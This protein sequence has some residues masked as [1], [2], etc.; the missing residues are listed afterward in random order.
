MKK[1]VAGVMTAAL[2]SGMLLAS[3]ATPN[4]VSNGDFENGMTG[5]IPKHIG[6]ATPENQLGTAG[7]KAEIVSGGHSGKCLKITQGNLVEGGS[8]S[9]FGRVEQNLISKEV[10]KEGSAYMFSA[11]VKAES[12][13]SNVSNPKVQLILDIAADQGDKDKNGNPVYHHQGEVV[14]SEEV[15]TSWKKIT[16]VTRMFTFEQQD[17]PN[18]QYKNTIGFHSSP[19]Y[20]GANPGFDQGL[21]MDTPIK[22]FTPYVILSGGPE[23]AVPLLIDDMELKKPIYNFIFNKANADSKVL[24]KESGTETY[25]HEGTDVAV[26]REAKEDAYFIYKFDF[27]K[28]TKDA[29]ISMNVGDDFKIDVATDP[30]GP[31]TNVANGKAL[32]M[33]NAYKA[34][35]IIDVTGYLNKNSENAVYMKFSDRTKGTTGTKKNGVTIRAL[36]VYS[37]TGALEFKSTP[38]NNTSTTASKN[39]AGQTSSAAGTVSNGKTP[40][41]N[42]VNTET[43]VITSG[44]D[45]V[46]ESGIVAESGEDVVSEEQQDSSAVMADSENEGGSLLWLWITLAVVVVLGGGGAALYFLVIKKKLQK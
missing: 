45:I 38:T 10:P 11:W 46:T 32:L 19:K 29:I 30:N 8:L 22:E 40:D 33:T 5:W 6:N 16:G 34:D 15:T 25:I 2:L 27:D 20:P 12:I 35:E 7:G 31:W 24:Y 43:D 4:L 3:A 14:A 1:I 42:S 44:D 17:G 13:P 18:T 41:N 28:N 37:E 21:K 26:Y 39:T 36:E 9:Y 23:T